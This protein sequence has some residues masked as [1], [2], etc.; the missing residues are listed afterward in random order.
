MCRSNA[1]IYAAMNTRRIPEMNEFALQLVDMGA[2]VN[3]VNTYGQ[4]AIMWASHRNNLR[5]AKKLIEAGVK[6]EVINKVN[7]W[8][9]NALS[10]AC[11]DDME[12]LL[13]KAGA[14]LPTKKE[15]ENAPRAVMLNRI[16]S[17]N[18]QRTD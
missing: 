1:L 17:F 13:R 5:L 2:D 18:R 14:V 4:T 7:D 12:N 9:E 11:G 8:G 16:S 15:S 3:V 6:K 10:E